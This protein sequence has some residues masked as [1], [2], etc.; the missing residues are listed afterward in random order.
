MAL[1][2]VADALE[3]VLA[4][5][6]PLASERLPIGACHGRVLAEELLALRT[7]PPADVS[8]MDGYALRASDVTD[9]PSDL[10]VI[11]EVAAGRPFPGAIK[12]HEAVRI[13]TGG[14]MPAG[15]DTVVIQEN[16]TRTGR[17]VIVSS[18][19]LAGRHIRAKGLD[20]KE[21]DVLLQRGRLLS[22]R[23]LGLAAAM[24]HP[25]LPVHR[26]TR[27]AVLATGDELVMPGEQPGPGQIV[28]SNGFSVMA[29][30]RQENAE[31]TDLGIVQDRVEDTVS[32]IRKAR[33]MKADV[34]VTMG[35]ASVGDYDLV[36]KSLAEEG[37]A[38]TFWK[39][40]MRP[41][42]PMMHGRLGDMHVLGLPGNPVSAYVCAFLFL[43]PLLR[44]LGGRA[45]IVPPTE[46]ALLGSDLPE[47]DERADYLRA[48]LS[49]SIRGALV[50]TPFPVQDSSLTQVLSQADCLVLRE[51][52]AVKAL[53]GSPCVILKLPF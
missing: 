41:G 36:Q 10:R 38:L 53:A 30:A 19:P 2:P 29:L 23:D 50:A 20:F 46:N 44:K 21:G 35:G 37:I 39:I 5:A 49:R 31:V 26:K 27:V 16:T 8:A 18:L 1:L 43:L 45:D 4:P 15:A 7:Q 12:S 47:N 17:M 25:L 14:E 34:L 48:T 3:R 22:G 13:F 33:E 11:G 42:R 32:A 28:Y 6:S 40:A 52:F 51:P 24:N 9:V